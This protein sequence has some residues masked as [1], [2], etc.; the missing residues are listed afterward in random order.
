MSYYECKRCNQRFNRNSDMKKHLERKKKC[1]RN[2]ESYKYTEEEINNLSL[3]LLE[4]KTPIEFVE[5]KF[6]CD[7][8]EKLFT[9]ADNLTRHKKKYVKK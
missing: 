7:L 1:P 9:R 5:K 4:N 2:I 6:K 3:T 8:C